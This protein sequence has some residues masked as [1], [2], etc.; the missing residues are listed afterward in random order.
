MLRWTP[1]AAALALAAVGFGL[2]SPGCA[3]ADTAVTRDASAL[4]PSG[5]RGALVWS[6]RDSAGRYRLVQRYRGVIRDAPVAPANRPFD[7]DLGLGRHNGIAAV[8]SRCRSGN[9][10]CRIFKLTLRTG[11]ETRVPDSAPGSCSE[12]APSYWRGTLAFVGRGP[13]CPHGLYVR[14]FGGHRFALTLIG[15][16]VL[17]IPATDIRRRTV[18]TLERQGARRAIVLRRFRGRRQVGS[19][20]LRGATGGLSSPVMSGGRV[21][22]TSFAPRRF[23]RARARC[24]A[25]VLSASRPGRIGPLAT[26]RGTILYQSGGIFRADQPRPVFR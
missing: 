19:C 21:L 15:P 10:G 6:R 14:R 7:P 17:T 22:W 2:V 8:Y 1:R 26:E 25:G 9:R 5:F 12:T 13:G 23:E 16:G 3:S 11:A 24:G 18:A 4:N 20:R